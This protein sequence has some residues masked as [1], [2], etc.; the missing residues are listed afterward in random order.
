[1][2]THE[3]SNI[4]DSALDGGDHPCG[5]WALELGSGEQGESAHSK[6]ISIGNAAVQ[7]RYHAR[8]GTMDVSWPD[9]H[10]LLGVTSAASLSDGRT[11]STDLYSAHTVTAERSDSAPGQSR[12][13]TIRNSGNGLPDLLQRIWLYE[14]KPWF[15]IEAELDK[16]A[17]SVGTRH[18]DPL[19]IRQDDPV[20]IPSAK[21]VRV[22]HVPF[23]NDMW[24]RFASQRIA[25]MKD[26]ELFSSEEVTA[27]YDDVIRQGLVIGSITHDTWKTAIDLRATH[28]H[29]A[30][31]DVYGGISSPTGVR[32]DT[33]DVLP[34]GTVHRD[35]VI[36]PR[37]FVGSFS[38]WRNGLDAYAEANAQIQPPLQWAGKVPAGWNSWA[39]Y[40]GKI[41]YQRYLAAAQYVHDTLVPEGFGKDRTI[42]INLDAFWS[43]LDAVQLKDAVADIRAM[44]TSGGTHFEPGIYWTP[45]AYWS[46]DLDAFVEGTD[47]RYRYRDILLKGPDGAPLPKV[48]GG[49][50]S[51][52][53]TP[54]QNFERLFT[55]ANCGGLVLRI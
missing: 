10:Q 42:Y 46:D 2:N 23:D 14:G 44:R 50:P 21:Q 18:F 28:G 17:S 51:I 26:G 54:E 37:I 48:D 29:L 8:T 5:E 45:F 55:S 4:K 36:S 7:I 47:R 6:D 49:V 34:H 53:R 20:R 1:V 33:H 12:V 30:S 22:L 11:I 32:S 9:G 19:V 15:A 24:F 39:A 52:R 43:R 27:I 31:I 40:G 41:D 13:Y 16:A 35:R 3:H 25:S 38:D